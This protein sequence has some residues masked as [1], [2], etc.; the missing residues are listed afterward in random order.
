MTML[1]VYAMGNECMNTLCSKYML[2]VREGLRADGRI[3]LPIMAL[4]L[5]RRQRSPHSLVNLLVF[6]ISVYSNTQ[7]LSRMKSDPFPGIFMH[8]NQNSRTV[9]TEPTHYFF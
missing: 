4:H 5:K 8:P 2:L 9:T 1:E 6:F 3:S 7:Y